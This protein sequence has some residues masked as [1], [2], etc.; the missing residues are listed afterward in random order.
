[1][2]TILQRDGRKLRRIIKKMVN[3]KYLYTFSIIIPE[4]NKKKPKRTQPA[5]YSP[6]IRRPVISRLEERKERKREE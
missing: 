4:E 1:M 2:V 3:K 5:I 6:K